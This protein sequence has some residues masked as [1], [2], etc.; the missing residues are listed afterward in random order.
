MPDL[1][2]RLHTPCPIWN[3][4]MGG[5]LAGPALVAAVCEGG[6]LGV[7]GSGGLPGDTVRELIQATRALTSR[8]FA[9]NIILP[10]SAGDDIEACFDARVPVLIL[11]WGDIQ[12][13]V[14][15]AHRRGMFVVAQCGGPE[16]AVAAADAGADAIIVQGTEAGGHVKAEQ[17]LSETL[18]ATLAA[19]GPVPVLAAGGLATGADIAAALDRG[20]RAVSLGTR[21]L[22]TTEAAAVSEYKSRIVAAHAADTVLTKMFDLGW[23]DAQ[24]RVIRNTTFDS[25]QAAG[26]P[27][28]GQRPGEGEE[29]GTIGAGDARVPLPRYSVYPPATGF[30]GDLDAAALYAGESVE[31]VTD[32]P[33]AAELLSRLMDELRAASA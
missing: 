16:D 12:P 21:F 7:L 18:A 17:P 26:S 25:W 20:A 31:R 6:G 22:A 15:D 3:A 10:M 5:G 29:I 24:H 11:F 32:I 19:L 30:A 27:P 28:S 9:A 13:Y 14:A 4:G 8:P 1:I 2:E 33:S 23:P